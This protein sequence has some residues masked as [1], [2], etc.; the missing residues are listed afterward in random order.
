MFQAG[1]NGFHERQAIDT[2]A[3]D[4]RTPGGVDLSRGCQEFRVRNILGRVSPAACDGLLQP[5]GS[6]A[7]EPRRWCQPGADGVPDRA[8]TSC[9][10]A[11]HLTRRADRSALF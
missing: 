5:A 3:V 4:D 2:S 8:A 10:P 9:R 1:A 7:S 11:G 6:A